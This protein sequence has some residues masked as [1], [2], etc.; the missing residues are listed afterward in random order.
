[1]EMVPALELLGDYT[2]G[3][4]G[5]VTTRQAQ[6]LG[7]DDVTLHRLRAAGLLETVRHGVHA[8]T[9]SAA[10]GARLEQAVW[11]SLRPA[12]RPGSAPSSTRTAASCRTS[13]PR[14]CTASATCRTRASS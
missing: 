5:M 9:S 8:T 4:W 14:G 3:Q 12:R 6:S 2:A 10:S 11:L 1:M 13:R 7:V